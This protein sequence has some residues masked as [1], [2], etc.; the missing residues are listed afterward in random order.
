MG[1]YW[2]A[3]IRWRTPAY[4]ITFFPLS[5]INNTYNIT[6]YWRGPNGKECAWM[7]GRAARYKLHATP[8]FIAQNAHRAFRCGER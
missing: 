6:V 1:A 7:F 3:R 2:S 5:I 8:R 4:C